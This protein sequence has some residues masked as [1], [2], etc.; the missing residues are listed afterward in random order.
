MTFQGLGLKAKVW[1]FGL[2]TGVCLGFSGLG[3][4]WYR[5]HGFG[6]YSPCVGLEKGLGS[7]GFVSALRIQDLGLVR[8]DWFAFRVYP[9]A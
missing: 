3:F 5:V 8:R 6:L 7:L 1:R 2:S 9:K 4:I